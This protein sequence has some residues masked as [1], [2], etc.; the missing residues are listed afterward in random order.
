[1]FLLALIKKLFKPAPDLICPRC[2]YPLDVYITQYA[3]C[4]HCNVTFETDYNLNNE[5]WLTGSSFYGKPND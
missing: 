4:D 1:M 5:V 3:Y 2:A